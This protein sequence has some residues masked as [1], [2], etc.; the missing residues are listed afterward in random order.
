MKNL[1]FFFSLLLLLISCSTANKSLEPE[2]GYA[3]VNGTKLYYEV[4]GSGEPI[5]FVHGN[6]GDIRHWDFQMEAFPEKFKVLRYDVRGYGNSSV[7]DT[8]TSYRDCDDL[9][10]LMDYLEIEKAHIC[11][12]SMGSRIAIDFAL[13]YPDRCLSLIPI[14]P[15]PGGWGGGQ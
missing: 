15:W 9:S 2:N 12:L 5:V 1:I 10:A 4:G 8:A 11:G 3:E 6:F 7:P 14:G 13:A